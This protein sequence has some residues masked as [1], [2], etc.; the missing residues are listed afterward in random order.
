MDDSQRPPTSPNYMEDLTKILSS[1][2]PGKISGDLSQHIYSRTTTTLHSCN[3][4][5]DHI[6]SFDHSECLLPLNAVRV[7]KEVIVQPEG[8]TGAEMV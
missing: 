7:K 5:H 2:G 6:Y 8:V 1:P 3:N 4:M